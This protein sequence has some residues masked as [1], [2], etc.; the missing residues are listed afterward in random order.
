MKAEGFR[1]VLAEQGQE[2]ALLALAQKVE[3][4]SARVA[5]IDTRPQSL[6]ASDE[7]AEGTERPADSPPSPLPLAPDTGKGNK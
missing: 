3:E 1:A 6:T 7:G 5:A 4:L 2:G